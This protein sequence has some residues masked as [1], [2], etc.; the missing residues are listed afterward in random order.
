M[1]LVVGEIVRPH[2]I[3]G[4]VVVD[5]RTDEPAER[6][7]PGS[8]LLTDPGGTLLGGRP[9]PAPPPDA[10]RP[11]PSLTVEAARPHLGRMIVVFEGVYERDV[12]E[13]LRRVVLCVDSADLPAPS[14]PDEFHDHQLIGLAAVDGAGEPLGE[15]VR[16]DHAPA[17]DL[18]VVRRPDG[19]LALVP[20]VSAIVPSVDLTAGRVVIT[21]PDGL[22]DL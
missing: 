7:A 6:F 19:K 21:P 22:F 4:E 3:R 1:L 16:I 18:L 9:A 12:A 20:F 17:A 2:G 5:V 15:V 11:P 13:A 10:W 8:V 14:D